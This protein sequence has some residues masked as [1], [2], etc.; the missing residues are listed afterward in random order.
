MCIYSLY[1]HIYMCIYSSLQHWWRW[2]SRKKGG[3]FSRRFAC[4]GMARCSLWIECVLCRLNVFSIYRMR[5]CS[6]YIECVLYG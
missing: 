5:M 2:C 1:V 3:G 6:L 4:V